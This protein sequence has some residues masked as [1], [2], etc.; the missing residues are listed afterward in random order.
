MKRIGGSRKR[1]RYRFK[2]EIKDR[3]KIPLTRYFQKLEAGDRVSLIAEP[4]I[5]KGMYHPRFFGKTGIIKS[6]VGTCYEVLIN[7][8]KKEKT[9]IIHPIHLKRC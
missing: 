3:G 1:T 8:H 4:S 9:L 7:D 2:K 6:K 5:Q